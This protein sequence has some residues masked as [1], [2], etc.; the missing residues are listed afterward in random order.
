MNKQ[1]SA[2]MQRRGELQ[3]RI[4]AQREQ[5]GQLGA[6]CQAPLALAAQ[7]VTAIRFVRSHPAL[8]AGVVA[9]FMIR[10]R[11]VTG[12][13]KAGWRVWKGYRFFN[14]LAEKFAPKN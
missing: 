3:A 9:L 6:R 5:V 13:V 4:A 7:G 12:L 1:M 14:T 8:A 11:G 10:R 2:V